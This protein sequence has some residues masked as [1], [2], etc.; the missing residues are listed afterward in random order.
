[1]Q[2]HKASHSLLWVKYIETKNLSVYPQTMSK[3]GI[4]D[5]DEYI[6][7]QK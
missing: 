1:M 5:A 3:I 4:P 7:Q 6:A 2:S